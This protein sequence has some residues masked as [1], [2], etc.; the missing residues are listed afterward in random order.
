MIPRLDRID[1][2]LCQAA[3]DNFEPRAAAKG[4]TFRKEYKRADS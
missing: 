1:I 3:T 2:E 4:I